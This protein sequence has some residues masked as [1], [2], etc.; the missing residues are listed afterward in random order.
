MCF[1]HKLKVVDIKER[2]ESSYFTSYILMAI[3]NKILDHWWGIRGI[4]NEFI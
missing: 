4:A 1:S 3:E 2:C